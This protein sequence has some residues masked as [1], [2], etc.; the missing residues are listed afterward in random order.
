MLNQRIELASVVQGFQVVEAA[1]RFVVDENLWDGFAAGGGDEPCP[2]GVVVG[3][4]D[5]FEGNFF[6][7]QELFRHFAIAA[8]SGG[9]N[10]YI[11]IHF[12]TSFRIW[13]S[14]VLKTPIFQQKFLARYLLCHKRMKLRCLAITLLMIGIFQQARADSCV[15]VL[16]EKALEYAGIDIHPMRSWREKIHKAPLLPRLQLG[17]ERYLRND[18]NVRLADSV[19]VSSSGVVVG[20]EETQQVASQNRNLNFSVKAIWDLNE[21]IFSQNDLQVSR[22][23]RDLARER[24]HLLSQVDQRYFEWLKLGSLQNKFHGRAKD[25]LKF[26]KSLLAADLDG[27]TGGWFSENEQLSACQEENPNSQN[28]LP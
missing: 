20:P 8:I 13:T 22:E 4:I 9:V 5:F 26:K 12:V 25:D 24:E 28:H 1:D 17:V 18:L 21:L 2:P 7:L 11:C 27:Y 23:I 3:Y 19:S 6:F 16:Q 10:F 15:Q 14:I